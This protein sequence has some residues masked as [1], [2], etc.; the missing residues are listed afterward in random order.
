MSSTMRDLEQRVEELEDPG[1][2]MGL[3]AGGWRTGQRMVQFMLLPTVMPEAEKKRVRR[4][5]DGEQVK[6]VG[7]GRALVLYDLSSLG[8]GTAGDLVPGVCQGCTTDGYDHEWKD[9]RRHYRAR[10]EHGEGA[11]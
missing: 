2:R 11:A 9:L 8:K 10:P 5:T 6:L 1:R 4:H 7:D 3:K